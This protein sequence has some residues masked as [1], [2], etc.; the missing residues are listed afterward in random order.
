MS[1]LLVRNLDGGRCARRRRG[2]SPDGTNGE[3]RAR[4][5]QAVTRMGQRCECQGGPPFINGG[6]GARATACPSLSPFV[7]GDNEGHARSCQWLPPFRNGVT[8]HVVLR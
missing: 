5:C 8:R 1:V 6:N 2:P 3:G 7:N 4:G